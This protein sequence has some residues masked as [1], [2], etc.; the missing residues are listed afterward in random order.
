MTYIVATAPGSASHTF[1]KQLEHHL[2]CKSTN[3]KDGEGGI[4]HLFLKTD[5]KNMILNK[6]NLNIFRKKTHIIY[7][8]IFPTNR[9]LSLLS[10][11]YNV[12]NILITYRNIYE[13]LNY[14]YKWQKY[15]HTGPLNFIEDAE[16][17]SKYEFNT[18]SFNVDLTLLLTLNFY[19]QWFYWI[20]KNKNQNFYLFSYNEITTLNKEY[21]SK[22]S[23]LFKKKNID[24]EFDKNIKN[25]IYK[26]EDFQIHDRHK[27]MIEEFIKYHND[28]DFNIIL[29]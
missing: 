23:E 28:I 20:Q 13:Q 24:L 26:K 27:N 8:H 25:N 2:K 22:I 12:K 1:V 18:N 11:Y 3:L 7:G 19:K 17:T 4:G 9:N 15:H 14:F 5:L 29:K 16:I 6:L 21:Q 10:R